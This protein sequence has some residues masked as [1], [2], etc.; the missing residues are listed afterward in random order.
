M[1]IHAGTDVAAGSRYE[2]FVY[3]QIMMSVEEITLEILNK[4]NPWVFSKKSVFDR[5][6]REYT[7]VPKCEWWKTHTK[8]YAYQ[9]TVPW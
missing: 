7:C 4:R 5:N 9:K 8:V 3:K 6:G 2:V 1:Y